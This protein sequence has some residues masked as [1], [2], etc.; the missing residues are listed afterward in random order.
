MGETVRK[1]Q[2]NIMDYPVQRTSTSY[3][4]HEYLGQI[5]NK[6]CQ[7]LRLLMCAFVIKLKSTQNVL[8]GLGSMLT[9][10]Y[11]DGYL[12]SSM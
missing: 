2:V 11:C 1:R 3:C 7:K 6:I 12:K 10:S 5:K 9:S 8:E 4:K